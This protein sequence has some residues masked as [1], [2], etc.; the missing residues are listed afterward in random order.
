MS[1]VKKN[2]IAE[3][4]VLYPHDQ[5]TLVQSV[6]LSFSDEL[7]NDLKGAVIEFSYHKWMI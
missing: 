4:W 7:K 2:Q 5:N 6:S 3:T 1:S